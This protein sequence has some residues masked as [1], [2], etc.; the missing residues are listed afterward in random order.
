MTSS[1]GKLAAGFLDG[2]LIPRGYV[3]NTY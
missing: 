1:W 3:E 2:F